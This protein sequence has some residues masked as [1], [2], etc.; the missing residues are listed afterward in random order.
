VKGL[1]PLNRLCKNIL[2]SGERSN[3]RGLT[4]PLRVVELRVR[5]HTNGKLVHE[6]SESAL[7]VSNKQPGGRRQQREGQNQK[8]G[9]TAPMD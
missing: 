8:V 3:T 2:T 9:Q 4:A 6:L 1:K 7:N 5:A